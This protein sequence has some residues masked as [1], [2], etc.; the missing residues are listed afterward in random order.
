MLWTS[1]SNKMYRVSNRG[2]IYRRVKSGWKRTG[3]SVTSEGY[4]SFGGSSKGKAWSRYVH[5]IV[6]ELFMPNSQNLPQ[7]D[8]SDRNRLNNRIENLRW[9]SYQQNSTNQV[10]RGCRRRGNRWVAYIKTNGVLQH[11]GT[12]DTEEE[13]HTAYLAAKK[14]QHPFFVSTP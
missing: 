14:R 5:R 8:H 13:A 11:L 6:A 9:A 1:P 10:G 2:T 3:T 7:V 12:F 4:Q